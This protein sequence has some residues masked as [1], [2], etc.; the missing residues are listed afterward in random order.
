MFKRIYVEITNSCNLNCKF[1]IGNKRKKQFLS[2][3]SFNILLDKLNGYTKYL[4]FHVMGEPLLHPQIG[5]LVSLANNRG[6]FVNITTNGY[7]I[8]NI[9]NMEGVRQLNI[10]LH[11]FN[12]KNKKSFE[13]YMKDIYNVTDMLVSNGTIIKY[14]LWINSKDNDQFIKSLSAYYGVSINDDSV[15]LADNVYLE[16]GREFVWPS[17]KNNYYN[18]EGTCLGCREQI[19]VLVDG[20]VVPCCLDSE[21]IINLGNIYNDD[22]CDIINSVLFQEIKSGFLKNKKVCDLCRKCSFYEVRGNYGGKRV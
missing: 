14:R 2:I 18:E 16:F 5:E 19:G 21:G 6:F 7:L 4:Y 8:N 10:S 13:D 11:S 12:I 17:L 15:K 3:D 1:C 22:L 20:T 9:S